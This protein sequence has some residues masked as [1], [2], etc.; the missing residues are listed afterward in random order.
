MRGFKFSVIV[1]FIEC[2]I[3]SAGFN[4]P[5]LKL[6]NVVRQL[7]LCIYIYIIYKKKLTIDFPQLFRHG[8]REPNDEVAGD[9]TNVY[10]TICK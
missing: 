8:D 6:L 1:I 9:L 4:Y 2:A 5:Q 7:F 10:I 3:K